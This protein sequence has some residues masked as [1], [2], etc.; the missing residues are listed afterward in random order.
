VD[1]VIDIFPTHQQQ[2]IRMQLSVNLLG[3]ISQIL[4]KRSDGAGRVAAWETLVAIPSVRNS[5]RE[6]K[7]YQISSMI[8][9][10]VKQGMTTLDQS[11]ATLVKESRISF[12]E[13]LARCKDPRELYNLMGREIG[14][15]DAA[16]AQ[17]AEL[18]G[19]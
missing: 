7:T 13:A 8:Q 15:D 1:R 18:G 2:Q 16:S 5:I 3:V 17:R 10:G 6:R 14:E 11:L 4:V 19:A 9:T 12:E